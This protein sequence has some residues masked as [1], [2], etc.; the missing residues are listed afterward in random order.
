V[1]TTAVDEV[2]AFPGTSFLVL[3]IWLALPSN[4]HIV[5]L[6]NALQ[7]FPLHHVTTAV[8]KFH[9]FRKGKDEI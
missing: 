3:P 5:F 4:P 2:V 7:F 9:F 8:I 6:H 1:A